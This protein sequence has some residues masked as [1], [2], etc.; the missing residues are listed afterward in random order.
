M[1]FMMLLFVFVFANRN[2]GAAGDGVNGEVMGV[3]G[4]MGIMGNYW[5]CGVGFFLV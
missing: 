4:V 1:I 3:V 2:I 5:A